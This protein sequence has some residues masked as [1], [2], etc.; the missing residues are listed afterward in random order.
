MGQRDMRKIYAGW[1][2][3]KLKKKLSEC[4]NEYS[5]I[6][7][8]HGLWAERDRREVQ[9]KIHQLT[10]ELAYRDARQELPIEFE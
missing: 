2:T 6:A 1:D 3:G 8:M 10:V 4:Q 9:Y 7:R 5:K